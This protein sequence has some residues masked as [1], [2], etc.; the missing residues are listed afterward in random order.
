MVMPPPPPPGQGRVFLGEYQGREVAIKAVHGLRGNTDGSPASRREGMVQVSAGGINVDDGSLNA[1]HLPPTV[2][3]Q[4]EALLMTLVS[5]HPNIVETYKCLASWRDMTDA[6]AEELV[7]ACNKGKVTGSRSL[8]LDGYLNQRWWLTQSPLQVI[9]YEWFMIMEYCSLG[10]LWSAI[11]GGVFHHPATVARRT[12][13][14]ND[15]T[16]GSSTK[17]AA[18]MHWDAL[19]VIDT[20]ADVVEALTFLHS[21]G[22]VHGDLK[23]R[24]M[25]ELLNKSGLDKSPTLPLSTSPRLPIYSW[26]PTTRMREDLRPS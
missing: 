24:T 11:V 3:L 14:A 20:L 19:A 22:I 5:G 12:A 2:H 17:T 4:F 21:N 8:S 7:A 13:N 10:S 25:N 6:M 1:D 18:A 9:Q 26:L 16:L 23:V 15:V